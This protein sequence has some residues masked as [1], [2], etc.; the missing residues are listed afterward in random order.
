MAQRTKDHSRC[1]AGMSTKEFKAYVEFIPSGGF[2]HAMTNHIT[3]VCQ[4]SNQVKHKIVQLPLIV[5]G[6]MPT[7]NVLVKTI[8]NHR[9]N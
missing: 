2:H 1:L 9:R 5:V 3:H 8:S 4:K 6:E 7:N